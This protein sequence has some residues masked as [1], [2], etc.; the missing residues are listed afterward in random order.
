[1]DDYYKIFMNVFQLL[2][3]SQK[4]QEGHDEIVSNIYFIL[5]PFFKNR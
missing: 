4:D 1:M 2:S 5:V 3:F